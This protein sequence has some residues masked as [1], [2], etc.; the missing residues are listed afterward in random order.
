MLPCLVCP[1]LHRCSTVALPPASDHDD[2]LDRALYIL[3]IGGSI[4]YNMYM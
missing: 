3:P 2:L 4:I 1:H